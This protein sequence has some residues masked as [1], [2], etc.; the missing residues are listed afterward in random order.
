MGEQERQFLDQPPVQPGE[1]PA[2]KKKWPIA[3]GVIVAVF[4]VTGAGFF[5]WHEQPSFC[6][7]I[8]HNPMD[9][10]VE[11]YYHDPTL[12]AATHKSADVSCLVCHKA[13]IRDQVTEGI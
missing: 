12:L 9:N 5:V 1:R 2:K 13:T 7:A 8:C 4:V 10:Y 6:N 3:L 11:G